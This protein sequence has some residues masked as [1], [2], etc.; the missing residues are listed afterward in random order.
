MG[1]NRSPKSV[2][3]QSNSGELLL[4]RQPITWLSALSPKKSKLEGAGHAFNRSLVQRTNG[5]VREQGR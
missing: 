2:K 4:G 1:T 5:P 3:I